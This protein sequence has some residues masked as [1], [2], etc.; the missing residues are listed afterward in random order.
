MEAGSGVFEFLSPRSIEWR[1]RFRISEQSFGPIL[2]GKGGDHDFSG[3]PGSSAV[4]VDCLYSY[5]RSWSPK[6]GFLSICHQ[7][8]S[9]GPEWRHRFRIS[10]QS[11]SRPNFS[12]KS[13]DVC[14][15]PALCAMFYRAIM[16]LRSIYFLKID[17][18]RD[19]PLR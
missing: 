11:M 8:L 12:R 1:H 9:N 13:S 18:V 15:P 17:V 19:P 6:T 7:N 10:E 5:S 3:N 2:Q 14:L 16:F 4:R